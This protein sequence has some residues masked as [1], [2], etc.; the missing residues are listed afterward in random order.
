MTL[1]KYIIAVGDR[2]RTCHG[3]RYMQAAFNVLATERPDLSERV[4][5]VPGLDPFYA[6]FDSPEASAFFDFLYEN[7]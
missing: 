1:D 5:T 6:D 7:W 3:E 4:R 2:A